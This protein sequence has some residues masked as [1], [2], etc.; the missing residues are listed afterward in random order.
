[1]G[2]AISPSRGEA[3]NTGITSSP[4]G[5][6]RQIEVREADTSLLPQVVYFCTGNQT[7]IVNGGT[8]FLSSESPVP[9]MARKDIAARMNPIATRWYQPTLVGGVMDEG[10]GTHQTPLAGDYMREVKRALD[11]LAGFEGD[12]ESES[13][14]IWVVSEIVFRYE[15]FG[16]C[17]IS[18]LIETQKIDPEI[19]EH[20][21]RAVGDL[22]HK[23]THKS[24]FWALTRALKSSSSAIR[25]G[26]NV[27]LAY[28]DDPEAIPAIKDGIEREQS[29]L[30]RKLLQRTLAQ[31]E[32]TARCPVSCAR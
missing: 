15:G 2:D 13:E 4:T 27:G 28:M 26:A 11:R 3:L 1:V 17:E 12:E 5:E 9:V 29:P 6:W 23:E 16:V 7:M 10:A 19:A 25:D 14:F 20:V 24:R 18:H 8:W 22:D 21:L 30:L 32:N 31:L